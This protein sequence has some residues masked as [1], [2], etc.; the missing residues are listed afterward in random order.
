MSHIEEMMKAIWIGIENL[1]DC[2]VVTL[3]SPAPRG[4]EMEKMKMTTKIERKFF[5]AF[6]IKPKKVKPIIC[7]K[8]Q[9]N[10]PCEFCIEQHGKCRAQINL[11]PKITDCI[12]LELICLLNFNTKSKDIVTLKEKILT[13]LCDILSYIRQHFPQPDTDIEIYT[14]VRALFGL[15]SEEK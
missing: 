4:A 9:E 14:Q 1:A 12:L 8:N 3:D 6:G 15:G 13:E 2:K 7:N 11:Y 10:I 5:D